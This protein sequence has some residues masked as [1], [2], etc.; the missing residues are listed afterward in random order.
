MFFKFYFLY[1][2]FLLFFH[3]N[4]ENPIIKFQCLVVCTTQTS[5]LLLDLPHKRHPTESP[6]W[7][8]LCRLWKPQSD[9][10][11]ISQCWEETTTGW[12]FGT[13]EFYF[14][15]YWEC[16][17]PNWLYHIFQRGRSTTNQMNI[18]IF[19]NIWDNPSHWL[20]CF[21]MVKPTNQTMLPWGPVFYRKWLCGR[22]QSHR[23]P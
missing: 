11:T 10:N 1:S 3:S 7:Q 19:H 15:I 12:C 8:S 14:S 21:K 5:F 2:N 17:H 6:H 18:F 23:H 4:S 16:H 13:M 9:A 22:V 20:I